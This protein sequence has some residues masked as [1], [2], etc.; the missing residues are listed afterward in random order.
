MYY[1]ANLS[2][3][4]I[5]IRRRLQLLFSGT[6]RSNLDPFDKFGVP[7]LWD[8][9]RQSYLVEN[10]ERDATEGVVPGVVVSGRFTL[11]IIIENEG[12]NLS[13]GQRSLVS[14]AR[15]LVKDS[16]M[17]IL[18]EATGTQDPAIGRCGILTLSLR[19]VRR[20]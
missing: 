1:P 9:L 14:L 11:G 12:S 6:R 18:D 20:L 17:L 16:K 4:V 13:V 15:A 3:P 7:R 19:S 2:G 10:T 8:A 5:L